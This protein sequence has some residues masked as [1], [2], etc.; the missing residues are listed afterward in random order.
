ML[1]YPLVLKNT[2]YKLLNCTI[3]FVGFQND[4][5]FNATIQNVSDLFHCLLSKLHH[6]VWSQISCWSFQIII[7]F[8]S[9]PSFLFFHIVTLLTVFALHSIFS[10]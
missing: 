10:L 6:V 7:T 4:I 2:A 9:F 5:S 1:S 3:R 8:H